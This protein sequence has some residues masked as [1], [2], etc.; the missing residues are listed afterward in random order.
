M[1]PQFHPVARLKEKKEFFKRGMRFLPFLFTLGNAF[2]GFC[3]IVLAMEGEYVAAAYCVFLAAIMDGLDGRVAR[4]INVESE[5][6]L[7][8][9]SLCDAIS[10]CVAPAFLAYIWS[11]RPLGFVGVVVGAVFLLAG[12]LRLARFNL[13]H[14]QQSVFFIGLPTP[15]AGCLVATTLLNF[16]L[17]RHKFGFMIFVA[18]LLV[19][20]AWL[21]ISSIRFPA[22]KRGSLKI[23][24]HYPIVVGMALFTVV[25]V[26]RFQIS[27]L[28]LFAAYFV[29]AFGLNLYGKIKCDEDYL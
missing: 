25:T 5:L 23:K 29:L 16:R 10:F 20:L 9:D 27:L 14:D 13:L 19:L 26:M 8:M 24:K 1:F 3:S 22:F 6:G 28:I 18:F 2:F 7:E 21:M 12:I 4:L 17:V 11:L 15:I